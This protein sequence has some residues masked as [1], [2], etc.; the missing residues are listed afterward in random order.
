MPNRETRLLARA[1]LIL[2]LMALST[3][4]VI[5][6]QPLQRQ[7]MAA[8]LAGLIGSSLLFGLAALWPQLALTASLSRWGAWLA[9]YG[10]AAGWFINLAAAVTG[11]LGVF[12]VSVAPAGGNSPADFALSAGLLSTA[13]A[14]FTSAFI[15][16]RGLN[17]RNA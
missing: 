5:H 15:A 12:P 4:F 8:H 2:F 3:G 7:V 1:G 11:I 17:P 13:V 16:L 10:F 6:A 9:I 14:L